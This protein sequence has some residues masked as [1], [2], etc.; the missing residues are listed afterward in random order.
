MLEQ[1][2][3]PQQRLEKFLQATEVAQ[4]LQ[5]DILKYGLAAAD[6]YC[7]DIDG[8]WLETWGDEEQENSYVKIITFLKSDD[9][10]AIQIRKVLQDEPLAEIATEIEQCLSASIENRVYAIKDILISKETTSDPNNNINLFDLAKQ[11][12]DKLEDIV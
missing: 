7:E 9:L 10:L 5:D 1:P 4:K 6:L 12:A 3:N 11:L 2:T 8:D